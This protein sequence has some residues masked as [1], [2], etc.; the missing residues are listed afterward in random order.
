MDRI[1]AHIRAK[2]QAEKDEVMAE[3]R[4]GRWHQIHYAQVCRD[5]DA[6]MNFELRVAREE[7]KRK[8]E[9]EEEEAGK[10]EV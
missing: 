9:E 3:I 10:L 7:Y 4:S 8:K 1:E 5:L 6:Q 2:C